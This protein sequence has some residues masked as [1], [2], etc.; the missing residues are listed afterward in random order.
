MAALQITT[1]ERDGATI[2][3][4]TGSASMLEIDPLTRTFDRLAAARPKRL[5]IDMTRLDFM[6]SLAL[7]QI[8]A[9]NRSVKMHGGTVV[10]A[11]PNADI[12]GVLDRCNIRALMPV[13]PTLDEA[14]A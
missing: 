14:L 5:V 12:T 4:M 2:A 8:V 6:A 7:G 13:V 11:G 3:T 1:T 9:V 10:L